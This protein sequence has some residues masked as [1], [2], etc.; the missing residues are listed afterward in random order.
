MPIVIH[1][2]FKGSIQLSIANGTRGSVFGWEFPR[3]TTYEQQQI[4][5]D[6]TSVVWK[7]SKLASVV[8]VH[9]PGLNSRLTPAALQKL[10]S[11]IPPE[12]P[13][14]IFPLV[15][16]AFYSQRETSKPIQI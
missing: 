5:A 2:N 8:Y 11:I 9:I 15:S 12:F 7:A 10:Q 1:S 6:S 16:M 3:E 4:F 14:D 13:T